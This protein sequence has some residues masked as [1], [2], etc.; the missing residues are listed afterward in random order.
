MSER[1]HVDGSV[2]FCVGKIHGMV[3]ATI[4]DLAFSSRHQGKPAKPAGREC[5]S[6]DWIKKRGTHLLEG[7]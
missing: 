7:L 4:E 5:L 1:V 2:S 3:E 6:T